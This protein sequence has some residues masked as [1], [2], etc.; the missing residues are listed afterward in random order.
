[1]TRILS[2]FAK[3][4]TL[5][6]L[7]L[8]LVIMGGVISWL[9]LGKEEMPE[10]EV[11]WLRIS[12]PYPGATASDVE[13]FITKPVEEKLKSVSG[14]QSLRSTSA[15]NSSSITVELDSNMDDRREL[16]ASIKDAVYE[17]QLPEDSARN[18][19]FFQFKSAA[20]AILDIGLYHKEAKLLSTEDRRTLQDVVNAL[21]NQILSLPELSEV[22]KSS[23]LKREI[24]IELDPIKLEKLQL[25][26][27]Q[28]ASLLKKHN[29]R[30]P[31]GHLMDPKET[32]LTLVSEY[33]TV[34]RL[35]N[36]ILR[37][38]L[39]REVA[40]LGDVATIVEGF[41]RSR[42]IRKVQGH[43]AIFLNIKKNTQYD[44]LTA[45]KALNRLLD[46]FQQ[47]RQ[48]SPVAI[49]LLDDESFDLRNRLSIVAWNGIIGFSLILVV[50][51]IFLDLRSG[52]WVAMGLPFTMGVTLI[53]LNITGDT[54][55][56]MTLASVI[57]VLGI[58]VDDAIILTESVSRQKR[59]EEKSFDAVVKGA[60]QV[61][62]PI[63][64]S[65]ITTCVAFM[66]LYFFGGRFGSFVKYIPFIVI[67][68]LAASL[69]ES[70][71]ILPAHLVGKDKKNKKSKYWFKPIED[72]YTKVI[73]TLLKYR[74]IVVLAFA[75][76]LPSSL[77]L[78]Q[79]KM[80]FVIFPREETREVFIKAHA[81]KDTNRF[82]MEKLTR[83]IEDIVLADLDKYVIGIRTR[84]GQGRRGG[85]VKEN[86]A[87][88]RIELVDKQ[89]RKVPLREILKD[90]EDKTNKLEGF[91]KIR[92]IKG[93]F[94]HGMSSPIDILIQENN[95]KSREDI[96]EAIRA[97]LEK[98][99]SVVNV[100]V[101]TPIKNPEFR[102]KVKTAE[103]DRLGI[104][105]ASLAIAARTYLEGSILYRITSGEEEIDVRLTV[106][107]AQKSKLDQVL[108]F[109]VEN[110]QG[111]LVPMRDVVEVDQSTVPV[112]IDRYNHKRTLHVYG[113]LADNAAKSPLEIATSLEN[114]LLKSI[115]S[116]YP[117]SI[118]QFK[119]EIEDSRQS[120]S[121]FLFAVILVSCLIYGI[122]ILLY[123]SI[124]IPFLIMLII[125][126]G[127]VG[128]ILAFW[129]HGFEQF[130]FFSVIGTLGMTGVVINDTIIMIDRLERQI[131]GKVEN[132]AKAVAEVAAT[133]LRAVCLT[134]ITT[135][136]GIF[137]T[138]YGL[139]GYDAMLAEMMLAMG[140]GLLFATWI[141]LVLVP[142]VYTIFKG[143]SFRFQP[144]LPVLL[145]GLLGAITPAPSEA[146]TITLDD[147]LKVM[148][149]HDPGYKAIL[150]DQEK[151][152]YEKFATELNDQLTLDLTG[153]VI[154]ELT[155][156]TQTSN[157][158]ATV[159]QFLADSGTTLALDLGHK[160][161]SDSESSTTL[162]F[163]I[164]QS[165]LRNRFGSERGLQKSIAKLESEETRLKMEEAY[166][167][168]T[169]ELIM[170]Y[171]DWYMSYQQLSH[172]KQNARESKALLTHV[173]KRFNR[174][175]AIDVD[176]EIAKL[177]LLEK[178]S[179][180]QM[181][182]QKF[183]SFTS[184]FEHYQGFSEPQKFTPAKTLP[185]MKETLPLDN[186]DELVKGSRLANLIKVQSELKSQERELSLE[187]MRDN[188]NLS[189]GFKQV[190]DQNNDPN[191][192][193]EITLG[194]D[195][196][197]PTPKSLQE[198]KLRHASYELT[199]TKADHA[200]QSIELLD[201]LSRLKIEITSLKNQIQ[202]AKRGVQLASRVFKR[203]KQRYEQG[204]IDFRTLSDAQNRLDRQRFSYITYQVDLAKAH[205]NWLEATDRLV[206]SIPGS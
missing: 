200:Q 26:S 116:K 17:A 88:L 66:P 152:D 77:W 70:M 90:W 197:L 102:L 73:E 53:C 27:S 5:A 62:L 43:E 107:E 196:T 175:I 202:T 123:Q 109:K 179:D 199:K 205:T 125:P 1:M 50:L 159:S 94:G 75:A 24:R 139:A 194:F 36:I 140:W 3:N 69:Y 92:F 39:D 51:F 32:R 21:E 78:Y 82:Q 67:T 195:W 108:D 96:A 38:N 201:K 182:E 16:I 105:P 170:R 55:N 185:M 95:N 103:L 119:G 33:E 148:Q 136:A 173:Q 100:D 147:Y 158:K 40:R 121:E 150:A 127:L 81:P 176:L 58:V 97:E 149:T 6:N 190:Q 135:V 4:L 160:A 128:V 153:S 166:E 47:T 114:G 2:Y 29:F 34:E 189:L 83:S 141:T 57:I 174:K 93:R 134:T 99:E 101:D 180:V 74:L 171:L 172:A 84:I 49:I 35:K 19:R 204:L 61:F 8:S 124:A 120:T 76:I 183:R 203:Q 98:D 122:L 165:I 206:P 68:M 56:N 193:K 42:S 41:E 25:S 155:A 163:R 52:F 151:V 186:A 161:L 198:T 79:Q 145:V 10:F 137:P 64:A 85:R 117:T 115:A 72:G 154:Q 44:I 110:R 113:D 89:T 31:S 63:V 168:H 133:R 130:G 126:F 111:Y 144:A 18:I 48:D 164:E 146:E 71:F 131:T 118:V 13:L 12:I 91:D 188:A 54:I 138:A 11:P 59:F 30:T 22:S 28:V 129:A 65:I 143:L 184:T 187:E 15:N 157:N 192:R 80:K 86:E 87:F 156:D 162:G 132:L 60:S 45:R 46:K 112:N 181:Q 20:K 7:T 169:S 14:I 104:E 167:A 142:C 177:Q 37:T 9:S 106:P 23:Y 191:T 178:Q